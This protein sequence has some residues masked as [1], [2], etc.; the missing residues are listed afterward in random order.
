MFIFRSTLGGEEIISH[1]DSL[2]IK[3]KNMDI[4]IVCLLPA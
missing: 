2:L 3:V 4:I 1:A